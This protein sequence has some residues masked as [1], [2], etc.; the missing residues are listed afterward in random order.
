MPSAG[1]PY[2]PG[3]GKYRYK[4]FFTRYFFLLNNKIYRYSFFL[5]IYPFGAFVNIF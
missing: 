3:V 5:V 1:L 4:Y 2:W